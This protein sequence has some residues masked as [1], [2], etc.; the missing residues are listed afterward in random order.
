MLVGRACHFL[1]LY[2]TES[3]LKQCTVCTEHTLNFMWIVHPNIHQGQ[4]F[5]ICHII[6]IQ[7]ITRSEM[8]SNQVRSVTVQNNKNT[9]Y[10][11]NITQGHT[12]GKKR[13]NKNKMCNE[14]KK[15]KTIRC[16][17]NNKMCKRQWDVQKN[18]KMCKKTIRCTKK[19]NKKTVYWDLINSNVNK[20][21]VQT[22]CSWYC[23]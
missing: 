14:I 7:G 5:F 16:A 17:K 20:R 11:S 8:Q 3:Q 6:V 18:N 1:L 19:E 15:C 13:R 4:G 9:N 12:Y 23:T 21:D 10:I 2:W 22:G